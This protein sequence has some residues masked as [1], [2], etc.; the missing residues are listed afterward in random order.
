MRRT[1]SHMAN[2]CHRLTHA[3][4]TDQ[5]LLH[6]VVGLEW[7]NF[8]VTIPVIE[9]AKQCCDYV[10]NTDKLETERTLLKR[11]DLLNCCKHKYSKWNAIKDIV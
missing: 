2:N 11:N 8:H 9:S 3:S 5:N 4:D 6:E 1:R 7:H 10:G